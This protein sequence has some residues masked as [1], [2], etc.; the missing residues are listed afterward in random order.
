VLLHGAAPLAYLAMH[1]APRA[2]PTPRF[3]IALGC[4]I[5]LAGCV[6]T[7][8]TRYGQLP[9]TAE[10][11]PHADPTNVEQ[12]AIE[13]QEICVGSSVASA[14]DLGDVLYYRAS[15]LPDGKL[16]VGYY[17]FFSE[18]RPWGNNWLTWTLLP[19]LAVDMFYTRAMFVGPGLQ[20]AIHGK[21]DVEGFRVIYELREDGALKIERAIADDGTHAPVYLSADDVMTLDPE[22]PTFYSDVWSHQLGG[23]GVRS[24][25]DLAYLHCYD[26]DHVRPLPDAVAEDFAL[27]GRANPAHLEQLGGFAIDGPSRAVSKAV[28]LPPKI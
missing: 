22:R 8:C 13:Q 20:R 27:A 3:R 21:G 28:A 9:K 26:R 19:A 6:Q 5:A 23:R 10:V 1:D 15:V 7:A 14:G 12:A 17:V 25:S 24:K 11:A 2:E 18:E 16:A 4:L